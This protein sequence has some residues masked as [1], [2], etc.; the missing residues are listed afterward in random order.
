MDSVTITRPDD[1]HLHLRDGATLD[2]VHLGGGRYEVD[3]YVDAQNDFGALRRR[4]FRAVVRGT[5]G[6]WELES[7]EF[8]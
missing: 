1:W 7:F 8:K 3:S 6:A 2:V 5:P 4:T